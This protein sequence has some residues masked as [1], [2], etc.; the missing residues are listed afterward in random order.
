MCLPIR[1]ST[2][3][4]ATEPCGGSTNITSGTSSNAKS[5]WPEEERS[6]SP[7]A[8]I[9]KETMPDATA[10][11]VMHLTADQPM[12]SSDGTRPLGIPVEVPSQIVICGS[13]LSWHLSTT[14]STEATKVAGTEISP[15]THSTSAAKPTPRAVTS[16]PP[17]IG[18]AAGT[19]DMTLAEYSYSNAIESAV[20][21]AKLGE[22]ST[23]TR[24][25][26]WAGIAHAICDEETLVAATGAN[27]PTRQD[28]SKALSPFI[29][30][31]LRS[32]PPS[33]LPEVRLPRLTTRGAAAYSNAAEE[34]ILPKSSALTATPTMPSS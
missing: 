12:H 9:A 34:P 10:G 2:V 13:V 5:N 29:M 1:D 28:N 24:P 16:T 32:V 30:E 6:D 7:A 21:S 19:I 31:T 4:P 14:P 8:R 33:W 26:L 23:G 25:G 22:I 3:P 20:K 27:V 15:K 17:L 18:D 11:G